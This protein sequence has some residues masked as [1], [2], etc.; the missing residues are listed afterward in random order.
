MLGG[1]QSEVEASQ[2]RPED[3][4]V[5]FHSR[6]PQST[7]CGA[8]WEIREVQDAIEDRHAEALDSLGALFYQSSLFFSGV[9]STALDRVASRRSQ[10]VRDTHGDTRSQRD[11][12]QNGTHPYDESVLNSELRPW[13]LALVVVCAV[14]LFAPSL[15]FP[16]VIDDYVQISE[17]RAVTEGAPLKSFF[18]DRSTTSSRDDYNTRIYRP[19]RNITFRALAATFGPRP[20][21]FRIANL[22]LY[23]IAIVLVFWLGQCV[24]I[25]RR[26]ALFSAAVFAFLPV[27]VEAV[28]YPSALGDLLSLDLELLGVILGFKACNIGDRKKA[29]ALGTGAVMCLALAMCAKEMAITGPALLLLLLAHRRPTSL[30]PVAWLGAALVT[31]TGAYLM[32]R[33]SVV[34]QLGQE[35]VNASTLKR[36]LTEAP[37]LLVG[38]LQIAF[39]P[40]GHRP[41]YV[42]VTPSA[43]ASFV[44]ALGFLGVVVLLRWIDRRHNGQTGFAFWFAWFVCALLPVLHIV[45][46]WADLADRFVLVS[47]VAVAFAIAEAGSVIAKKVSE[48]VFNTLAA[49]IVLVYAAAA[50]VEQGVWRSDYTLSAYAVAAEPNSSLAQEN[51]CLVALQKGLSEPALAA[52]DRG[53]EL[54]RDT[55]EMHGKRAYLLQTLGRHAEAERAAAK[56]LSLDPTNAVHHAMLG[57]LALV[58]GDVPRAIAHLSE[59]RRINP[60]HPSS[61]LLEAALAKQQGRYVDALAGYERVTT[62][63]PRVARFRFLAAD[64]ADKADRIAAKTEHCRACLLQD[65]TYTPC[66]D[67][68]GGPGTRGR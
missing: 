20:L 7:G 61:R 60:N 49:A 46:L 67:L 21:V 3:K 31:V 24:L 45:P 36:G 52:C 68:C 23:A 65:P 19:L 53:I 9:V 17:N 39:M 10:T 42:V 18:L 16:F 40:L 12:L 6:G 29:L 41:N 50:W 66:L 55:S 30:R 5:S 4:V 33:T 37:A 15:H 22:T 47:T 11:L 44:I 54:G 63:M 25:G 48:R 14:G 1:P 28:V 34:G 38:Y 2:A 27:H 57:D 35:A 8:A 32:L 59:C 58:R 26:S 13:P 43:F 51:F 64:A 62:Q 56:A